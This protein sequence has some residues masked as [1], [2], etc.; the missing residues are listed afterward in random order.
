MDAAKAR[1]CC[2]VDLI[3][4]LVRRGGAPVRGGIREIRLEGLTPAEKKICR[5]DYIDA[6]AGL[7]ADFSSP[8]WWANA[9]SEKNEHTSEHFKNLCLF[10]LL[11]KALKAV[12]DVIVYVVCNDA[13]ALQLWAWCGRAGIKITGVGKRP[14]VTGRFDEGVRTFKAVKAAFGVAIRAVVR[15]LY[16]FVVAGAHIRKNLDRTKDYYVIRSWINK[17]ALRQCVYAKDPYFGRLPETAVER[18]FNTLI[19]AGILNN[20][21][22]TVRGLKRVDALIVPE[23]YFLSLSDIVRALFRLSLRRTRLKRPVM[24]SGVDV[25]AIYEA[26]IEKG[27]L[28]A[29]YTKN[30][31]RYFIA[32]RLACSIR[33]GLYTQ[34]Y[35]NYAW[36]KMMILG[37]RKNRPQARILGFQHAFV[38]EDSFKYFTGAK[39]RDIAPLPDGIITMGRATKNILQ[40]YGNYPAGI[41]T[42]GCALRQEY[43]AGV[44]IFNRRR[45]GRVVVPLTM[46]AKE[47][48]LTLDFLC[49]SGLA[50]SGIKVIVRC[51]PAAP[52][53][54]FQRLLAEE[55]PD[56]FVFD[57]ARSV[58]EEL[59]Q[60]D[61]V[62]YTWTTVAAEALRMGLPV[63]YLDVLSPLRVDP[64]FECD[65]LKKSVSVPE[66][67]IP[68]MDGFYNM[69]DEAFSAEQAGAQS[70]LKD[71]FYPVTPKNLAPF[72]P[73]Q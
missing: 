28:D 17:D 32:A 16:L 53:E 69:T 34:T 40:S 19:V 50:S 35:E 27:Y 57:S 4:G 42:E 52:F 36:E 58:E 38:S 65:A 39:E 60:S 15:K 31:L 41:L 25:S 12:D 63:I 20:F 44:K 18:G 59:R 11:V 46:I 13:V 29:S 48:A 62:L 23:E 33:F 9:A 56:S 8:E 68:A 45:F 51:H 3:G 22:E 49:S 61:M 7:G 72:F 70:Y 26:E 64:L 37:I 55:L 2:F 30:I 24:F 71:Y 21:T 47:S 10:Y 54:T 5:L 1:Q 66:G 43:L 73:G 6:I 14:F 67:L